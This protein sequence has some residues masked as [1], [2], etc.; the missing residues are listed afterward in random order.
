M[1]APLPLPFTDT[2]SHMRPFISMTLLLSGQIAFRAPMF[3]VMTAGPIHA[4]FNV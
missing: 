3:K 4:Y 1:T 2:H